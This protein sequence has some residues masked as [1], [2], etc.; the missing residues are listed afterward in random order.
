MLLVASSVLVLLFHTLFV[1]PF[2]YFS[3]DNAELY[4][5]WLIMLSQALHSGDWPFLDPTRLPARFHSRLWSRA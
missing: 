5:A 1:E 4:F 3:T 2:Y